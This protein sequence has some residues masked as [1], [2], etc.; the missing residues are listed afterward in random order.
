MS[1]PR[2]IV[3]ARASVTARHWPCPWFRLA[4]GIDYHPARK[5]RARLLSPV[6]W[7]LTVGRLAP[8]RQALPMVLSAIRLPMPEMLRLYR[9]ASCKF[10]YFQDQNTAP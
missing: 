7:A 1:L 8:D 3:V 4:R 6:A 10:T 9:T 5:P 2:D